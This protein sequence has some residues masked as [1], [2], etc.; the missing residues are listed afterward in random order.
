MH[1][2]PPN[3]AKTIRKLKNFLITINADLIL[4]REKIE[5]SD[6][7][8]SSF[9]KNQYDEMHYLIMALED[10]RYIHHCGIDWRSVVREV[11]NIIKGKK[12]GGASTSDM[13]MVRTITEFKE[14]NFYRKLYESILAFIINFKYSKRQI[15]DCY[16]NNAFFGSHLYGIR[17]ATKKCFKKYSIDELTL[18]EKAQLAAMLQ[19]P[20]PLHPSITWE[21]KLLTRARYAKSLWVRIKNSNN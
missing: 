9:D 21:A 19:I 11:V 15:I 1:E 2:Q 5:E 8:Y 16:I 7:L 12:H 13:Q 14:R 4:I 20:R 18:D 3:N 17:K 10:R 6:D